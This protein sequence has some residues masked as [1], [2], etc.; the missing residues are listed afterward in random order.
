MT[1]GVKRKVFFV[2]AVVFAAF[3]LLGV[4][5]GIFYNNYNEIY[6]IPRNIGGVM[7]ASEYDLDTHN[8]EAV[9]NGEWEFFYNKWIVTD[10]YDGEADAMLLMPGFWTDEGYGRKAY[11]SYRAVVTNLPPGAKI[12][13]T[14]SSCP[15]A[16]RMFINGE[17]CTVSGTVSKDASENSPPPHPNE[18]R[19]I[20]VP[21]NGQAVIV[22]ELSASSYGGFPTIVAIKPARDN[23]SQTRYI[24]FG[25]IVLG[26]MIAI[27]LLDVL[28]NFGFLSKQRQFSS[29]LLLLTVVLHF[30]TSK[31]IYL[32]P[33]IYS[34]SIHYGRILELNF[35]T[36]VLLLAV[37][38]F[39]LVKTGQVQ[40]SRKSILAM[41]L[42]AVVGITGY[43]L[44]QGFRWQLVAALTAFSGC[45][46]LF[47]KLA[48]GIAEKKRF[49][50]V[51]I[52]MLFVL[53]VA[54]N[55]QMLDNL[56]FIFV[57][58]ETPM[59][60]FMLLFS[61]VLGIQTFLRIRESSAAQVKALQ[62]EKEINA[63]RHIAY[64]AQVNPHFIF[65]VL[66]GIEDLYRKDLK[67]GEK[68]LEQF[69]SHL[70]QHIDSGNRDLITFTAELDN[71]LNYVELENLR[72]AESIEVLFD[73]D[74]QDFYVPTLSLQ[75][76]IDNAIRHS[77]VT[78][79]P[80]GIIS[81]RSELTA[82]N[83]V[84]ITVSDNGSGFDAGR[85]RRNAAGLK[86]TVER[87]KLLQGAE[88]SIESAAEAGTKISITIP[89]EQATQNGISGG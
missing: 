73:I 10:G 6:H 32:K 89:L 76:L 30:F 12:M 13:L 43:F 1:N 75:P 72:R 56:G 68:A 42:P 52:G 85:I 63:V 15:I 26:I 45:F 8:L 55:M 64:Q 70:R 18:K 34:M 77:G 39:H 57:L 20:T 5:F 81:I 35:I 19:V 29:V 79:K 74:F 38:F 40:A 66:S 44:L 7:D 50:A 61:A 51:N 84:R 88:V 54:F 16:F 86:N 87:F 3:L 78:K 83:A 9:L 65:N 25:Y 22:V 37:F 82:E 31:E 17:I 33:G 11:A 53:T 60:I 71:V 24:N 46:Y 47:W 28:L 49:A 2:M 21:E 59:S 48:E 23:I 14:M 41:A 80:D 4:A 67:R 69:A 27:L 36:G 58:M 62:L